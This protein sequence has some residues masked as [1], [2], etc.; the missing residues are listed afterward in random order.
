[1]IK[2]DS[3]LH[4]FYVAVYILVGVGALMSLLGFM[5]FCGAWRN[6]KCLLI[7]FFALL[8]LVFVA[9]LTCG[10][11]AYSHQEQV[12]QYIERSMY[13]TVLHHYHREK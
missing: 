6:S 13:D 8:V 3:H 11:L 9:E 5:G 7:S 1:M 2:L 12:K 4:E 10:I